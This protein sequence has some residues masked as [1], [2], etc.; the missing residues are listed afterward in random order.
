MLTTK[1]GKETIASNIVKYGKLTTGAVALPIASDYFDFKAGAII[2]AP[3]ANTAN[4]FFG[5]SAV[6]VGTGFPLRPGESLKVPV[7]E[8][9]NLYVISVAAQN[10]NWIGL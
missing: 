6:A 8:L 5:D 10:L 1:V 2:L 3:V 4:I 9:K 7:E